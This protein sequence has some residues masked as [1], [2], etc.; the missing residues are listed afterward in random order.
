MT[1]VPAM[2]A[3]S[4]VPDVLAGHDTCE[5]LRSANKRTG[6]GVSDMARTKAASGRGGSEPAAPNALQRII[7]ER[8]NEM[9]WT[10]EDVERRGGPSHSTLYSI[11]SVKQFKSAP[12]HATL[13]KLAR[14]LDLPLDIL[15]SAAGQAAGYGLESVPT[16]LESARGLRVIA[17]TFD[18]LDP[19]R[20][21]TAERIMRALLDEMKSETTGS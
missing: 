17:A 9:G 12:R 21:R 16:T 13:Q 19:S 1:A 5:R 10:F 20:Q 7:R 6:R 15:R 14:G 4:E 3:T 2:N 8:M 18:K 11:V